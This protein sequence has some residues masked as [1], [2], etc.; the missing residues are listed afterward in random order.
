MSQE[1]TVVATPAGVGAGTEAPAVPPVLEL[2]KFTQTIPIPP[3][4]TAEI[5]RLHADTVTKAK[6]FEVARATFNE[7]C[8]GTRV[9]VGVPTDAPWNINA[10]ATAF[11]KVPNPMPVQLV[12]SEAGQG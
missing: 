5:K 12:N 3:A 10:D 8:R 4:A 7:F 6:A 1:E 9:I 2:P 11:E